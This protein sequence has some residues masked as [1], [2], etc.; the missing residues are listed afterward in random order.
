MKTLYGLFAIVLVFL[1]VNVNAQQLTT[2]MLLRVTSPASI[3]ATYDYGAPS[4]FGPTTLAGTVTG[5]AAWGQT[6]GADSLGCVPFTND[7]TGKV[8]LVRRGACS[9]SLKIYHAQ[10][11]GAVGAI[12]INNPEN[13]TPNA[14]VGMLG[15][16]SASAV[17]IPSVFLPLSDGSIISDEVDMGTA[18]SVSYFIPSIDEAA[19]IYAYATPISQ[20]KTLDSF[21]IRI[22]NNDNDP[23]TNVVATVNI[24]E[25]SGNI[26]TLTENIGQ[27]D[28]GTGEYYYVQSTYTPADL[29]VY[30]IEYTV[31]SDSGTFANEVLNGG[32][33]ITDHTWSNS[34]NENLRGI[35]YSGWETNLRYHIG[36]TYF[37]TAMEEVTHV[38]FALANPDSLEAQSFDILLYDADSNDDGLVDAFDT[39]TAIAA[40]TYVIDSSMITPNDTI[41]VE[42]FSL[43]V[44]PE[45]MLSPNQAYVAMVEY[46]ALSAA[47][48]GLLA[49]P[50]YL[51]SN[52]S[53]FVEDNTFLVTNSDAGVPELSNWSAATNAAAYVKLHTKGYVT[54]TQEVRK[55][56]DTQVTLFP[57][58]TTEVV[59][60][61]LNLNEVSEV[62]N[63][64]I[65]DIQGRILK[66]ESFNNIKDEVITLNV[67]NLA[68]GNYFIHVQTDEGYRT[69]NFVVIK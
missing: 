38:S 67:S 63:V 14:T 2:P 3:A 10:L 54:G 41:L 59:N 43:G 22:Y 36:N 9:F 31:A 19:G 15:G 69:K 52:R 68:K 4:D 16:D 66:S 35:F 55:L 37:A 28:P 21:N 62:V 18:V 30:A 6:M 44:T 56:E 53:G 39:W 33:E 46:N 20:I 25:P 26:V 24:T 40:T 45:I 58:P 42:L 64:Q 57:N 61:D 32:F 8:A 12:I 51:H 17:M 29:G 65:I 49:A 60:L 11:A 48:D 5:D 7:L 47:N 23:E 50:E 13:A 34:T 27:I 1:A